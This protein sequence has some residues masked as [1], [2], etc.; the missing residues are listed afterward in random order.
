[1]VTLT[2]CDDGQPRPMTHVHEGRWAFL[3]VARLDDDD[4]N[5]LFLTRF[6]GGLRA[7]IDVSK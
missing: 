5:Y 4:Q 3:G 7:L 6:G 1:M 2:G